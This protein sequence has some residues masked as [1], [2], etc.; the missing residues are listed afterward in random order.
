MVTQAYVGGHKGWCGKTA[1]TLS[2]FQGFQ[3]R[4][5]GFITVVRYCE[6]SNRREKDWLIFS[7]K[8]HFIHTIFCTSELDL[9]LASLSTQFKPNFPAYWPLKFSSLLPP[10]V[11]EGGIYLFPV[12]LHLCRRFLISVIFLNLVILITVV[13]HS[14]LA[15]LQVLWPDSLRGLFSTG[16]LQSLS[17]LQ[18]FFTFSLSLSLFFFF[19]SF[20]FSRN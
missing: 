6:L 8:R 2:I 16:Y 13:I 15:D 18:T 5:P 14:W 19:S 7:I 20:S 10:V 1:Q 9:T 3:F 11:S 4:A 17:V 12:F